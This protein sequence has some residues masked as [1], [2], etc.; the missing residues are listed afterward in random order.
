[1]PA[2]QCK[3]TLLLDYDYNKQYSK[4]TVVNN[5]DK[6][7]EAP[8]DDDDNGQLT[9]ADYE[10]L[11]T[12]SKSIGDHFTFASERSW[13]HSDVAFQAS[14]ES[15]LIGE[16]F[17]LNISNLDKGLSQVPFC[18]RQ[19]LPEQM[20]T[21]QELSGMP[22]TTFQKPQL[23]AGDQR[24]L[25]LLQSNA[26]D[27]KLEKAPKIETNVEKRLP[28]EAELAESLRSANISE[29]T[30]H[31]KS[32][33]LPSSSGQT[34]PIKPPPGNAPKVASKSNQTADIQDWLDD[35]LNEN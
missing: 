23:S 25:N 22:R 9:A 21:D 24:I 3:D 6:Y 12:A 19:G 34:N 15:S 5:W 14:E 30:S 1:M 31:A 33:P 16:L 13:L 20:F 11:L 18:V 10:Q 26:N 27:N 35:I 2:V 32:T 17:K 4:R 29:L 7:A 28:I 8:D